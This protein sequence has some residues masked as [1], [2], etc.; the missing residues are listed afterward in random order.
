MPKAVA[1]ALTIDLARARA[2]WHQRQGL[3]AP[4]EGSIGEVI[5]ATGWLRTLGGV[6]VYLAARARKP[7]LTR[8]A[9][10]AAKDAQQV[11]VSPAVRGCIYLVPRGH[12][13]LALRLAEEQHRKRIERDLEKAGTSLREVTERGEAVLGTLRA[14]GP[15]M[16]DA[17]RRT[18]PDGAVRSLGEQGKKAGVSSTLSP[19]LRELEFAGKVERTLDG[20]RLDTERYLWR[21]AR[22]SPFIGAKVPDTAEAR[23]VAVAEL[24]FAWVG[25]ATV[26]DFAEWTGLAQRD[27]KVA[28]EKAALVP[29][30][31]TGYAADA[32][33]P[34]S[35]LPLLKEPQA[36]SKA[37]RLLAFEDNF[38]VLHG[39]L[40]HLTDAKHHGRSLAPWGPS[41]TTTIGEAKHISSR[42]IVTG[43]GMVGLWEYDPDAR[44]VVTV[45]FDALDASQQKELAALGEETAAFLGNEIGHAK[46]FS[47]D[48]DDD[49][50]ARV[51]ALEA[52]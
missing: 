19:S 52:M 27:A 11:Q 32:F 22:K 25:P 20:G 30:A 7:G 26:K 37:V 24:F 33:A 9:L 3:A 31:V 42:A 39:G 47:L 13:A 45:T 4:A 21:A 14:K 50:R 36:P 38:L 1:K 5:A 41:K 43:D 51:K 40:R 35:D 34:A 15:L 46:S 17:L 6:D 48:T 10:D 8:A 12:V 18:L 49:V 23:H 28:I 2:H 16:T 29:I 44:K